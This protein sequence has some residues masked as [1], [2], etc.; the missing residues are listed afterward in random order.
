MGYLFLELILFAL[1]CSLILT[2]LFYFFL[3]LQL[4]EKIK[5]WKE[6]VSIKDKYF[7]WTMLVAFLISPFI[8]IIDN[9]FFLI[10]SNIFLAWS[11]YVSKRST[12]RYI[13]LA[14]YMVISNIFI[15][16][17]FFSFPENWIQ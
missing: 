11:F 16:L 13:L 6:F 17:S 15:G 7:I 1:I 9:I 8:F 12:V 3:F 10:A 4:G 5:D 14:L 2:L